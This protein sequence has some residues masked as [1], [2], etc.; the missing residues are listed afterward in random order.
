MHASELENTRLGP[1]AGRAIRT[2]PKLA[3][4]VDDV[5][6]L[7]ARERVF[8]RDVISAISG[9]GLSPV[10]LIPALVVVTPLSGVPLLTSLTG[11]IIFLV[12]AHMLLQCERLWLPAWVLNRW[13]KG[14]LIVKGFSYL[15]RPAAWVDHRTDKRLAALAYRPLVLV[16][17]LLC[18]FCGAVMPLLEFIPFSSSLVGLSVAL[19]ALGMLA[20]DGLLII[21]GAM[22]IAGV[23]SMI[24]HAF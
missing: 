22:P 3:E 17:Q 5:I 14:D 10:L 12:S 16:P 2:R 1:Q 21:L 9:A 13:I 24:A 18:L 6:A 8:V 7:G 11:I 15:R 23:V 4:L 19:M 20:R